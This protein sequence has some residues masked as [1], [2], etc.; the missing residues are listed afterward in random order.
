[1]AR[2]AIALSLLVLPLLQFVNGEHKGCDLYHGRW[3]YDN[4]Y[5][6]YHS[7]QCRF[8]HEAFDCQGNGRPDKLY[9]KYRWQPSACN[10]PRFDGVGF[11]RRF[12]NKRIMF[13]G[14][15]LGLNQWQSLVCLLHVATPQ[16]A[17]KYKFQKAGRLSTFTLTE[18][19]VSVMFTWT[20][21]LVQ[22]TPSTLQGRVL[23]LD[24][25]DDPEA[26]EGIDVLIFNTWHHWRTKGRKQKWDF[27]QDGK[28]LHKDMDRLA[29]YER[30]LRTWARWVDKN[31]DPLKTKVFFQEPHPIIFGC[32]ELG[33][34]TKGKSCSG[35]TQPIFAASSP[36]FQ[37]P[38]EVVLEKVMRTIWQPVHLLKTTSLSQQRK[39]AHPSIYGNHENRLGMDCSHW[40]LAGVPDTWNLLLYAEL[41]N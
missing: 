13:V 31:A 11:L 18:F 14:D 5:P 27:I 38:A 40:C 9:L 16:P 26:W 34:P 33:K 7:S 3:V 20:A 41:I 37:H 15:S 39:D 19:N 24:H 25:L 35:E 1:M 32:K 22:V 28:H 8:I 6:L 4:S 21:F 2:V 17:A 36:R 30:A 23:R 10:L 12:R 29:A